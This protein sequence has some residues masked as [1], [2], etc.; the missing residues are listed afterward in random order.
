MGEADRYS[1]Y[2]RPRKRLTLGQ[3]GN[4]LVGLVTVN[5]IFF[6]LLLTIRV[7]YVYFDPDKT[8]FYSQVVPYF[9]LPAQLSTLVERP[10]TLLTNMFTHV[11]GEYVLSGIFLL[12]SNMLWLW[13]FGFI[14][15]EL[16]GNRKLVPVYIYGGLVGGLAF[17]LSCYLIPSYRPFINTSYIAGSNAATMGVA[18]ATTVLAPGYRFFRQLNGGIPIWVLMLA[19]II[20]DFA[21]FASAPYSIAHLCGAGA[22]FL[23]VYLIRKGYDTGSWMINLYDW[24]MNLF[25][26]EK[27][28]DRTSIKEKVFYN[29]QGRKPFKKTSNVTQQ[30]VDEILDKISQKGYHFLTDEEKNILKRAS[31]EDL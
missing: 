8:A 18:M 7:V 12:L 6:L 22:G 3:D 16:A 5:I 29:A 30:R 19:Y 9:Q 4:A 31:E 15:Q 14:F 17:I 2:G 20:I 13:A 25:N 24:L 26:P 21:G 11:G 23:F 27:K 1:D 28:K 10:W